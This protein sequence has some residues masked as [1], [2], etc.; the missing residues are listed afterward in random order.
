[1]PQDNPNGAMVCL[2]VAC[3]GTMDRRSIKKK[4]IFVIKQ[5]GLFSEAALALFF[6]YVGK[7]QNKC[8]TLADR[9]G[10]VPVLLE[11]IT[12]FRNWET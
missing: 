9:R 3:R 4:R 7:L 1:M 8:S 10:E 11:Q 2:A 6:K 12:S 5:I